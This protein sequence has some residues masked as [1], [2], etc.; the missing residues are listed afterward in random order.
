M[1]KRVFNPQKMPKVSRENDSK[2]FDGRREA[3]LGTEK[4]PAQ[5]SVASS[6][7]ETEIKAVCEERGWVCSITIDREQPEETV[8][9][10]RLLNPPRPVVSSARTGRNDACPCGS[11]KKYK[12]CCAA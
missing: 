10:D 4:N 1:G 3:R 7:R 12:K 2:V 8:D 6:E 9:F 11:G 5:V